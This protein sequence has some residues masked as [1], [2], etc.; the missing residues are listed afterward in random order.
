MTTANFF[1]FSF[2]CA[3]SN[4]RGEFF[5]PAYDCSDILDNA[6]LAKDGFYWVKFHEMVPKKVCSVTPVQFV[7][8]TWKIYF[9][10]LT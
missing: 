8:K 10:G 2:F 5:N 1:C 4:S 3:G 6:K 7:L 9:R